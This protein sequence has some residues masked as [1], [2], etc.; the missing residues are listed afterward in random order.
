MKSKPQKLLYQSKDL[1]TTLVHICHIIYVVNG[2]QFAILLTKSLPRLTFFLTKDSVL[3]TDW[4]ETED[5]LLRC[6][7]SYLIAGFNKMVKTDDNILAATF[8]QQ[9]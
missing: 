3:A 8:L 9:N 6:W 4:L 7:W 5:N 2:N 1:F